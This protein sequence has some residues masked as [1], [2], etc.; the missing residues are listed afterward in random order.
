MAAV[1]AGIRWVQLRDHEADDH[2]FR[3]AAERLIPRLRVL[4]PEILISINARL[5]L[6]IDFDTAFHTGSHGPSPD[7][8][9]CRGVRRPIGYS[10][11]SLE[12]ASELVGHEPDYL[13][14]SPVFETSSKPGAI[15][16]G[17]AALQTVAAAVAPVPLYALGGI[18]GQNARQCLDA[19]AAGV[20]AISAVLAG[21]DVS[22][23]AHD[24][25]MHLEAVSYR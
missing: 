13:M 15:P 12:E 11:H 25:L 7:E 14:F 20:A 10:V 23:A 18:T 2:D 5:E 22:S 9:I 17:P 8:V 1:E 4:V 24:L 21:P 6:A 19:G 3:T 16:A